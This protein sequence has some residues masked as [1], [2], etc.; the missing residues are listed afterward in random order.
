LVNKSYC[1]FN[2][3]YSRDD[4]FKKIEDMDLDKHSNLEQ[5]K[6]DC[7]KFFI[8][9]PQKY[10]H[11]FYNTKVLGDYI[12]QSKN[13]EK[14][15]E[16][17]G[18]ENCKF[19]Y[20]LSTPKSKDCFDY[21]EWG[22][23][24]E[25]VYESIVCGVNL[26]NIKFSWVVQNN[27]TNIS[28]SMHCSGCND[29]FGCIALRN[30]QYCILNKQYTK[31]QYE[32]LVPK[33]IKHMNDMPYIS[34][35]KNPAT[36]SGQVY[37]YGEFFP[38]EF[39][40]YSYNETVQDFFPIS[41]EESINRGY[42]W[43]DREKRNYEINIENEKIPDSITKTSEDIV[44]KIIECSHKGECNEQCTEAFKIIESEYSFYKRMNLPLPRLCPNCRHYA[45]LKQRNPLKLWHR[46][47]MKEG[48]H[49]EFE[50]SYSPDRPEIVYCEKCYQQEVY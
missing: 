29:C 19:C 30:K 38:S 47:C 26:N 9:Y 4:Y 28:Y 21:V 41:K 45:R 39:S 46:K 32:E 18:S 2:K 6:L 42:K 48:C 44:G 7:E 23:S 31:E 15:Y 3:Q 25:L 14:S 12:Y 10:Y 8:K 13:V 37:K 5:H 16:V 40:L 20:F 11:G 1:I 49:N 22:D 24:A 27:S 17:F 35:G 34:Q 43:K 50:T 36:G 33:I